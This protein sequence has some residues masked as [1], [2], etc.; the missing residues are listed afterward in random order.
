MGGRYRGTSGDMKEFDDGDYVSYSD[1]AELL[2]AAEAMSVALH[3]NQGW[4]CWMPNDLME[5]QR[6]EADFHE[7]TKALAAFRAKHPKP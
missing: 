7:A 3:K 6:A 4:N 5:K 1:Y 2:A